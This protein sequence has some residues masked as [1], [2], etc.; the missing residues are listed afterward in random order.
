[1]QHVVVEGAARQHVRCRWGACIRVQGSARSGGD[2]GR[3][4]ALWDVSPC[5]ILQGSVKAGSGRLVLNPQVTPALSKAF[6]W[7]CRHGGAGAR[8]LHSQPGPVGSVRQGAVEGVGC[9]DRTRSST[10][11]WER[12]GK[13]VMLETTTRMAEAKFVGFK[14]RFVNQL[15]RNFL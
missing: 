8:F 3:C 11:L 7:F 2:R 14:R 4:P 13:R 9:Y 5:V 15:A 1:M 10:A 6:L 12:T